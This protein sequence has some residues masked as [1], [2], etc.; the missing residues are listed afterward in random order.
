MVLGDG[1]KHSFLRARSASTGTVPVTAPFHTF[2]KICPSFLFFVLRYFT[3]A[4][5]G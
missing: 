5:R 1:I 2:F 3:F 4:S